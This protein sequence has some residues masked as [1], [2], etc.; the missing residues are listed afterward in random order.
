MKIYNVIIIWN[1]EIRR[2]ENVKEIE[3]GRR[4]VSFIDGTIHRFFSDLPYEIESYYTGD[5]PDELPK[6]PIQ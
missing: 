3:M 1:G 2:F 4:F 6:E 5:K